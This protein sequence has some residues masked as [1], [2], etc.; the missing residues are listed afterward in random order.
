MKVVIDTDPGGDDAIALM[1]LASLCHQGRLQLSSV[2]TAAGNVGAEITWRNACGLLGLCDIR[3]V[4]VGIGEAVAATRDAA[5]I[6]GEDGLGGLSGALPEPPTHTLKPGSVDLLTTELGD[7]SKAPS[8][9]A[10]APLSNLAGAE[11]SAPG[12]LHTASQIIIMGGALS[13]GNVTPAAEFN[14]F[15]DPSA[16]AAVLAAS[17][18]IK[19]V[20]LETSSGLMLDRD[21]AMQ[22]TSGFDA[23]PAARFF[24]ELCAFMATREAVFSGRSTV[25]GF[26]VH[27]AATVAWLAYPELFEMQKLRVSVDT[28]KGDAR[29][30]LQETDGPHAVEC[31]IAT[32]VDAPALL[33]TMGRDLRMLFEQLSMHASQ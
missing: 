5:E 4:P 18:R 14:F 1:W 32:R 10:V 25:T 3:Q 30:Q 28:G 7:T 20:T 33:A 29:G 22:I 31:N 24:R 16:A 26:P 2:T 19:L 27:D 23:L 9:L 6:H 8:L 11:T 12:I 13:G 17:D 21:L 15:F